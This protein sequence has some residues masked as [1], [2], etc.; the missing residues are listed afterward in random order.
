MD[1]FV[2]YSPFPGDEITHGGDRETDDVVHAMG[3]DGLD[4]RPPLV[5]STPV[6]VESGKVQG[7]MIRIMGKKDAKGMSG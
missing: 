3:V 5:A 6:R 2:D 1:N 7:R 4:P